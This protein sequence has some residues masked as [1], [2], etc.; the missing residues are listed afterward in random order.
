M[1]TFQP[2]PELTPDQ[3]EALRAG[4]EANGVLVPITVDQHGRILDGHNRKQI[5]DELGIPCP[6]TVHPVSDDQQATDLA[7]ALNCERRHLSR[8]QV[9]EIV[10]AEI[11]RRPEDSDRAI[12][13][14]V[15]CSPS[16]VGAVRRPDGVSKLDTPTMSREAAEE[17]ARDIERVLLE[18]REMTGGLVHLAL[19]NGVPAAEVVMALTTARMKA[20]SRA[21]DP[22][23]AQVFREA[24]FD[25]LVGATMAMAPTKATVL[26]PEDAK[27]EVVA[28][29]ASLADSLL[30]HED[31]PRTREVVT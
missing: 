25:P 16:T 1:T 5:A 14:R 6:E 4:I 27:A 31:N 3:Y 15:G 11:V 23:V 26:L 30:D 20:E 29:I 9:R 18:L 10:A 28:T 13:R 7:V 12:A 22:L 2:M 8:E 19:T 21:S 17:R 24:V